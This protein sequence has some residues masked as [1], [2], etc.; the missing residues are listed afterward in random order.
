MPTRVRRSSGAASREG[1]EGPSTN[2]PE[3]SLEAIRRA[4][5]AACRDMVAHGLTQGTSGNIGVRWRDGLL[6]TPSGVPYD[7][8]TPEEMVFVG[9]DG[10]TEGRLAPT[11]EW[12][13]HSAVL[14]ARPELGAVVHAHPTYATALAMHGRTIPAAHYMIAAAG[15]PT[16]RCAP[17]AT[18]GTQELSDRVVEALEGR[19]ACLLANHGLLAAGPTLQRA[20]WLAVEVETLARQYIIA[21][22]LGAPAI[23]PDDEIARVVEKF[24]GYGPRDT[25]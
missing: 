10:R 16:I 15:G 20:L 22:Q 18:Y 2:A 6:V 24:K 3:E 12:R 14:A 7:E 11:S 9:A 4:M 17:Y 8:M 23:L 25:E 5:V 19:T 21:L 1:R 13:I